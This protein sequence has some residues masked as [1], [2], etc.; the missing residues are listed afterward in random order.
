MTMKYNQLSQDYRD[1]TLA[2]ALYQREVEFFHYDFDRANYEILLN[3]LPPGE[4]RS[5]IEQRLKETHVQI[6]RVE[7]IHAAL[8]ARITDPEAHAAAV[9]RT[10]K[11]REA[12][13]P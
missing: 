11:K 2:E 12:A 7:C 6:E 10:A 13:K 3:D 4:F 1:D 5:Q 8:T 9:A